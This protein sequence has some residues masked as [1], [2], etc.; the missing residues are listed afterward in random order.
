MQLGVV[1]SLPLQA[2]VLVEQVGDERQV[3]LVD[4]ADHVGRGDE[5]AAPQF[6]GLLEHELSATQEVLFLEENGRFY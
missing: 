3:E 2:G 6:G 1:F 5:R 4:A